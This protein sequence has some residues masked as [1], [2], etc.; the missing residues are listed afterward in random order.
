MGRHGRRHDVSNCPLG[1]RRQDRL[2][3]WLRHFR[4]TRVSLRRR[5]LRSWW[6]ASF[7]TVMVTSSRST[8]CAICMPC[9]RCEWELRF[10]TLLRIWV[11]QFRLFSATTRPR[12]AD[13]IGNAVGWIDRG[14]AKRLNLAG[15]ALSQFKRASGH[16]LGGP[17]LKFVGSYLNTQRRGWHK[18]RGRT[19]D[20]MVQGNQ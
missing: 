17:M 12:N 10:L 18:R 20:T 6:R 11:R 13:E 16:P 7:A 3:K 5:V 4:Q 1:A 8:A 9:P 14:P 15:C 19:S 2:R